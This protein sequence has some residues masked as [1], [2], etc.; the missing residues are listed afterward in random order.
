MKIRLIL[1]AFAILTI[2]SC[3]DNKVAEETKTAET[4]V[5]KKNSFSL[6]NLTD[7]NWQKG[8]GIKYKMFLTDY[9]KEKEELIKNGKTLELADGQLVP[10]LGYEVAG[11]YI[12][13]FLNEDAIKYSAAAEFPNEITVK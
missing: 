10:Y 6:T 8:V 3:K 4:A 13:I 12:Q 2:I 7:E 11:T 5:E 9:S 1:C